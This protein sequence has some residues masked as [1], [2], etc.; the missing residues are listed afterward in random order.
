MTEETFNKILNDLLNFMFKAHDT[1]TKSTAISFISD[2]ILENKLNLISPINSKKIAIKL[3]E[4]YSLSTLQAAES[5][6]ESL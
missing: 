1:I 2:A 6:K 3:V 4:V 5:I